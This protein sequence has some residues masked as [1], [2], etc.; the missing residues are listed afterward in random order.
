MLAINNQVHSERV[1]VGQEFVASERGD[2]VSLHTNNCLDLVEVGLK[3][4][5]RVNE[6][7]VNNDVVGVKFGHKPCKR[8]SNGVFLL[9]VVDSDLLLVFDVTYLVGIIGYSSTDATAGERNVWYLNIVE[10]L[11]DKV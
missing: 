10:L 11:Y 8:E 4:T 3:L 5:S 9:M 2:R 1:E 7:I 6:A